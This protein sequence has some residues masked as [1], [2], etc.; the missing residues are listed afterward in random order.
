[1]AN[2]KPFSI[3]KD[4]TEHVS[5]GTAMREACQIAQEQGVSNMSI[6]E[7]NAEIS[8]ARKERKG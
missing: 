5:G 1:M 7:I 3:E 6:E 4:E 8:M 2:G